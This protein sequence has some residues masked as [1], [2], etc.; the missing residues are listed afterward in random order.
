MTAT[1]APPRSRPRCRW[2][3]GSARQTDRA[4]ARTAQRPRLPAGA[5][6][7]ERTPSR[8]QGLLSMPSARAAKTGRHPLPVTPVTG[9]A[10]M[11]VTGTGGMIATET[12]AM[13]RIGIEGMTETVGTT[14]G[15]GTGGM[16]ETEGMTRTGIAAAGHGQDRVR[17]GGMT[18]TVTGGMT[19]TGGA[20]AAGAGTEGGVRAGATQEMCSRTRCALLPTRIRTQS[21]RATAEA[22]PSPSRRRPSPLPFL[23][24]AVAR[25]RGLQ[26]SMAPRG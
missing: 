9:T 17:E 6:Q 24:S 11:T 13:T 12:G 16:T 7:T 23:A 5:T 15:T 2:R 26:A 18:G 8:V 19:V 14:A 3:L 10:G 20:A 4:R 21:A 1:S 25:C 22:G